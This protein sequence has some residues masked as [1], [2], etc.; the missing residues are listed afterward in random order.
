MHYAPYPGRRESR[1]ELFFWFGP[2]ERLVIESWMKEFGILVPQ[3][4]VALWVDTVEEIALKV[5]P[6]YDQQVCPLRN[7]IS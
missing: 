3:D 6:F 7:L 2:I 1:P 4:L 5:R